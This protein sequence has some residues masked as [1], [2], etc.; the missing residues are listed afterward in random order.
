MREWQEEGY[1]KHADN[2][3]RRKDDEKA[4]LRFE[5]SRR[6]KHSQRLAAASAFAA[7]ELARGVDEFEGTLR[8]LQSDGDAAGDDDFGAGGGA[9]RTDV[10]AAEHL[11]KL[12][13]LDEAAQKSM[14]AESKA[15]L[16]RLRT[17][18]LEE[19]AARKASTCASVPRAS[20][21]RS[22]SLP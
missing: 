3:T 15:Y 13:K 16:S 17:R 14:G 6:Q 19:D 4:K 9:H 11:R 8:R 12:E 5:L 2:M 1:A 7:D 10:S 20:C 22:M 21:W 18:K